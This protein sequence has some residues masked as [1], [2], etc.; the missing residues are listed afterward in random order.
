MTPYNL[1]N[2]NGDPHS[3][4][5]PLHTPHSTLHTPHST[6]YTP[7]FPLY[8]P[9]STLYTPHST[10][11]TP[12]STLYTPHATLHTPHCRLV[13]GE[14]VQDCSNKLLQKS[15]LRDCISMCFDSSHVSAASNRDGC[16]ILILLTWLHWSCLSEKNLFKTLPFFLVDMPSVNHTMMPWPHGP[17]FGASM[18]LRLVRGVLL[19]WDRFTKKCLGDRNRIGLS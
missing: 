7:H 4:L 3:T 1:G 2:F 19:R 8:T 12:H 13:T 5:Y 16:P 10:L 6:L 11:Y 15:V 17:I 18:D 9:H 14:Y